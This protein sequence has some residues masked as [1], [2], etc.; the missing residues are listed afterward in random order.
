MTTHAAQAQTCRKGGI[1]YCCLRSQA[2][3]GSRAHALPPPPLL[4]DNSASSS[5]TL[6]VERSWHEC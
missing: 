1:L 5:S 4:L 3:T 6:I 2:T